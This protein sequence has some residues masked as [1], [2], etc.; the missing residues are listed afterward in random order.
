VALLVIAPDVLRALTHATRQ[1]A[2][3]ATPPPTEG[4]G[5]PPD[6][7]AV[8]GAA[9]PPP[10]T[11]LPTPSRA[12]LLR[13][14]DIGLAREAAAAILGSDFRDS[15]GADHR[16]LLPPGVHVLGTMGALVLP[17]AH[18][19]TVRAWLDNRGLSYRVS[20]GPRF[21]AA[22]DSNTTADE[23]SRHGSGN[24][25]G[26]CCCC[27]DKERAGDTPPTDT[28]DAALAA[29]T[30]WSKGSGGDGA[31]IT[32]GI[33]DSGIDPGR[34]QVNLAGF[35]EFHPQT[36]D[37][38]STWPRD[39]AS[40]LHG[41]DIAGL[42]AGVAPAA[43]ILVAAVLTSETAEGIGGTEE[44]TA[45]GIDW[46]VRQGADVVNC[47]FGAPGWSDAW[48][49][50]ARNLQ[51]LGVPMVAA[52]GNHAGQPLFPARF[53]DVLGVGA[54]ASG[55]GAA[56]WSAQG[57]A[58]DSTGS[59]LPS[60]AKPDVWLPGDHL[61]SPTGGSPLSGTSYAAPL[62]A[63]ALCTTLT[64]TLA[65]GPQSTAAI[66]AASA[67]L[68]SLASTPGASMTTNSQ[69]AF[70]QQILPT[71]T[72]FRAED[73][74]GVLVAVLLRNGSTN[75]WIFDANRVWPDEELTLIPITG[76]VTFPPNAVTFTAPAYMEDT[77][78]GGALSQNDPPASHDKRYFIK[79]GTV[80]L[81]FMAA[82][83]TAGSAAIEYGHPA[84]DDRLTPYG[85]NRYLPTA[86][87]RLVPAPAGFYPGWKKHRKAY[88]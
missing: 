80:T 56:S 16:S 48:S 61:P 49:K 26:C 23:D 2:R 67:T 41:T 63:A 17:R 3:M 29:L 45:A 18:E 87:L 27:T 37:I 64:Q 62:A 74:Y 1:R 14:R 8:G 57:V 12:E 43:Q 4:S 88:Y 84:P 11:E 55:G 79:N 58:T 34:V 40:S 73:Q 42:A 25:S 31:G 77:P 47:S 53:D 81:L 44:Q 7:Q 51:A 46:L 24:G 69:T 13:S 39:F 5:A 19:A 50:A 38:V 21:V 52:M 60:H 86:T 9:P 28:V 20:H 32:L 59:P 65:S 72:G 75:T 70:G 10:T 54:L 15:P 33:A 68:S 78:T 35:A 76:A 36:G 71:D 85:G 22:D 66:S 30:T 83:S 82:Q 6:R